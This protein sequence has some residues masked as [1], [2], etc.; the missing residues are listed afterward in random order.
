MRGER[1]RDK[2]EKGRDGAKEQV[3]EEDERR[4]KKRGGMRQRG[5]R[6]GGGEIE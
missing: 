5:D 4:E 2:D 1:K 3:R 6:E